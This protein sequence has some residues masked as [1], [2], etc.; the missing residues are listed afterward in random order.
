MHVFLENLERSKL[1]LKKVP[2]NSRIPT[3]IDSLFF[4]F[5]TVFAQFPKELFN[6]QLPQIIEKYLYMSIK[7]DLVSLKQYIQSE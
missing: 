2:I 7:I 4:T 5:Y 1:F 6:I 3:K